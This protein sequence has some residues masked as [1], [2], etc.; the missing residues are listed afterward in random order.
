MAQ[1]VNPVRKKDDTAML[2]QLGGTAAGAAFGGPAG[3]GIGS[4]LGGIAGQAATDGGEGRMAAIQR[5]SGNYQTPQMTAEDPSETLRK[6]RMALASQPT[7]VQEQYGPMLQ[8]AA[9]KQ[10]RGMA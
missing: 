2:L 4:Q 7:Q 10:R 6:A 5:R 3:A 8:A 1:Q 9:L